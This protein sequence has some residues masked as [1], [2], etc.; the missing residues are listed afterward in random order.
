MT[1]L[2]LAAPLLLAVPGWIP[3]RRALRRGSRR[4][5]AAWVGAWALTLAVGLP[6]LGRAVPDGGARLFP[7]ASA[8][9]QAMLQWVR[10]GSGCEGEPACFL[11]QHALHAAVF[12]AATL[13]TAGLAGL[14]FAAV[15]FGWMG[16]YAAALGTAAGRPALAVLLAWHP[17]AVIR[18][19]AYLALGVALAEPLA[20]R[21]LPTLPGRARWLAAGLAGLL[22]D[23]LLKATLAEAWRRAL[24]RPLL[25]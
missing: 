23:V 17:W 16:A 22:L 6:P 11:P 5:A 14:V 21:G 12:A 18:V 1:A 9:A 2:S 7:G 8:Y 25:P 24:L 3:F 13:A 19:A 10:T 20:R 4:R 15:L